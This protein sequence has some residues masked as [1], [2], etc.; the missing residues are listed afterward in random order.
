MHFGGWKKLHKNKT[1][2]LELDQEFIVESVR[3]HKTWT[4]VEFCFN[5]DRNPKIFPKIWSTLN[6]HNFFDNASIHK[7]F[8]VLKSYESELF[9]SWVYDTQGH[10]LPLSLEKTRSEFQQ[11][12]RLNHQTDVHHPTKW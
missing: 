12:F 6:N 2:F 4:L 3:E 7:I 11:N 1:S 9:I 5:L 10:D 8:G